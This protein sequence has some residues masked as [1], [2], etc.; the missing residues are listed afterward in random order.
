MG[1]NKRNW[2]ADIFTGIQVALYAG[3]KFEI[4]ENGK[5]IS[6]DLPHLL[7]DAPT[8]F[9]ALAFEVWYE[10]FKTQKNV[11]SLF[12]QYPSD[13]LDQKK[14][15]QYIQRALKDIDFESGCGLIFYLYDRYISGDFDEQEENWSKEQDS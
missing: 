1:K 9:S 8:F 12:E 14:N 15:E 3:K 6:T 4:N 13:A 2:A 7:W 11:Q 5:T 10:W